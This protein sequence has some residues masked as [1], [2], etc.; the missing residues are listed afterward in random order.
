MKRATIA[1]VFL[2]MTIASTHTAQGQTTDADFH[3]AV[4]DYQQASDRASRLATA[5]KVIK[6]AAAMDQMPPNI[7]KNTRGNDSRCSLSKDD[8]K[9]TEETD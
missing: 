9:I 1:V 5:E 2:V 3:Q 4:A 7:D 8:N 6:L